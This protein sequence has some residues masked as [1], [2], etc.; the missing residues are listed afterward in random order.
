MAI[1]LRRECRSI[2]V[3]QP[4]RSGLPLNASPLLGTAGAYNNHNSMVLI[5]IQPFAFKK[6]F[7][8]VAVLLCLS[9]ALCLADSLFMTLHS[10]PYGRQPNHIQPVP[11]SIPER[12]AQPPLPVAGQ[13]VDG[14]FAPD[15][16]CILPGTFDLD[17]TI[18]WLMHRS[19]KVGGRSYIPLC[20]YAGSWKYHAASSTL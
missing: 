16:G 6:I 8:L 10:T 5:S 7:L 20:T 11:F 9:S 12:T 4:P 3:E 15:S 17:P 13:S 1:P 14:R 18:N 19:G 2:S